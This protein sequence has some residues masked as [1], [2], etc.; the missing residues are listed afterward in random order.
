MIRWCLLRTSADRKDE[1]EVLFAFSSEWRC[2]S[3]R[4]FQYLTD[5]VLFQ[6]VLSPPPPPP[7][8]PS[9]S[10]SCPPPSS[11]SSSSFTPPFL[12][13][14][15]CFSLFLSLLVLLLFSSLLFSS[16]LCSALLLSSPLLNRSL[17]FFRLL[18]FLSFLL[19]PTLLSLSSF[20]LRRPSLPHGR[21]ARAV[22]ADVVAAASSVPR[23]SPVRRA[24]PSS[25]LRLSEPADEPLS[26]V[27][28]ESQ[29]V[30]PFEAGRGARCSRHR[31]RGG[32][33]ERREAAEGGEGRH[34]GHRTAAAA[35][36]GRRW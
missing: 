6:L 1:V 26:H 21:Q 19:T 24:P 10:S 36:L 31:R 11:S 15:S 20:L 13:P 2:F 28:E 32:C 8:P 18:L 33:R 14:P 16:P 35:S 34:G 29:G 27:R 17:T 5:F 25:A 30:A 22:H 23:S 9:S 4:A 3:W 7:P 12:F